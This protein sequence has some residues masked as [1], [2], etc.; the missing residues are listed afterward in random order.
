MTTNKKQTK[1]TTIEQLYKAGFTFDS[2]EI[3]KAHGKAVE[4]PSIKKHIT[5]CY[6]APSEKK[7]EQWKKETEIAE[8][9]NAT[10]TVVYTASMYAFTVRS[11]FMLE[12]VKGVTYVS[13]Y[14]GKPTRRFALLGTLEENQKAILKQA[15]KDK[16]KK[17]LKGAYAQLGKAYGITEQ[18]KELKAC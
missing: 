10:E 18:L 7:L 1:Q 5:E 15:K 6:K 17:G 14:K 3:A 12:G 13:G 8:S 2:K 4:V 11:K 9:I 16:G